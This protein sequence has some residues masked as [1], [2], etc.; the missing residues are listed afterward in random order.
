ME[1]SKNGIELIKKF[2]G[3]NLNAYYC[4]SGVLTIGYGH[5][6]NVKNNQVITQEEAERLLKEDLKECE[7]LV[8]TCEN[9][10][11]N[12][13]Q[14]QFDSLVSFTFNC[15]YASLLTL[16]NNRNAN[17]VANAL[18][19]YVNG[20]N[21]YL[22][23]LYNRRVAEKELFE[24][25]MN[26]SNNIIYNVA[27]LQRECNIQGFK[28]K[29]NNY[30]KIDNIGG[31]LTLSALPTV[32]KGAKGNITKFIQYYVGA[33]VD[34]IFG[35]ETERKVKEYQKERGLLADGIVGKNTWRSL[36]C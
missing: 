11:F 21:G 27:Y 28:D 18:L 6:A 32:R 35:E 25:D 26:T 23:G 30:L 8:N 17:E 24:K 34:G 36:I 22:E 3:C 20:S 12:L 13:N 19:L 14:N 7:H 2:E 15:G 33:T 1:I 29:N 10:T 31:E 16:C 9:I 4:P 5:T